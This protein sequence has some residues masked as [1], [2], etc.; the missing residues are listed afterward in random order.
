MR[1]FP[2]QVRDHS[3]DSGRRQLQV[4]GAHLR[5][6][7]QRP[8]VKMVKAEFFFVPHVVLVLFVLLL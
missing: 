7:A 6:A 8:E 4:D 5:S 3:A 1:C 2:L